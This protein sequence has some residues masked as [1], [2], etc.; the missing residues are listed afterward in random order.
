MDQTDTG[1]PCDHHGIDKTWAYISPR[2]GR[3]T[4]FGGVRLPKRAKPPPPMTKK[5]RH[6]RKAMQGEKSNQQQRHETRN[7]NRGRD[8]NSDGNISMCVSISSSCITASAM[9]SWHGY[10]LFCL[11]LPRSR[12]WCIFRPPRPMCAMWPYP[13]PA[14]R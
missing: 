3:R 8:G 9:Q 7:M 6:S 12:S 10:L 1:M 13:T 14:P 5:G 2:I 4:N 11:S